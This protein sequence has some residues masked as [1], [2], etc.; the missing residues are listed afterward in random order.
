MR[1][2]SEVRS[3]HSPWGPCCNFPILYDLSSSQDAVHCCFSIGHRSCLFRPLFLMKGVHSLALWKNLYIIAFLCA[4][5][6]VLVSAW[7]LVLM[8]SYIFV[9]VF[10]MSI[11]VVVF[12]RNPRDALVCI[13]IFKFKINTLVLDKL[14]PQQQTKQSFVMYIWGH[15]NSFLF[16][17]WSVLCTLCPCEYTYLLCV[18]LPSKLATFQHFVSLSYS[19]LCIILHHSDR[20]YGKSCGSYVLMHSKISLVNVKLMQLIFTVHVCKAGAAFILV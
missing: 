20:I 14:T 8:H 18:D 3:W 15:L 9:C 17:V 2:F 6:G 7:I 12:S 5:V 13:Y 16:T 4:R 19:V 11:E 10:I 1:S